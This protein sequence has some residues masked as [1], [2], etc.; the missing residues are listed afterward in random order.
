MAPNLIPNLEPEGVTVFPPPQPS[1][2]FASLPL[3][4]LHGSDQLWAR[5]S[6]VSSALGLRHTSMSERI[7]EAQ[8]RGEL[9]SDDVRKG[10]RPADVSVAPASH[11][12]AS[13]TGSPRGCTMLSPRAVERLA[14]T[15]RGP[16]GAEL[17]EQLT[18]AS[19]LVDQLRDLGDRLAAALE[20]LQAYELAEVDANTFNAS[21]G[22]TPKCQ[23][24]GKS[25]DPL[26]GGCR[27]D[28]GPIRTTRRPSK[29]RP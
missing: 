25:I 9:V 28:A 22:L 29:E 19:G 14:M 13:L 3:W 26:C 18:Q 2:P 1:E 5:V 11:S 24:C 10:V 20:A 6:D 17:R 16:R 8:R 23:C 27:A 12:P 21:L 4:G 15:R 7:A